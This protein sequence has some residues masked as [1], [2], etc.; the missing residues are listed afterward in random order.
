MSVYLVLRKQKSWVQNSDAMFNHSD[1][2]QECDRW[3]DEQT[4][5]LKKCGQLDVWQK[6]NNLW[7][8]SYPQISITKAGH[9]SIQINKDTLEL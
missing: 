4:E 2:V 8:G 6:H 7:R 1:K 3:T 5:V 9:L